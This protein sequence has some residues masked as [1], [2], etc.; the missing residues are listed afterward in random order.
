MGGEIQVTN[1]NPEFDIIASQSGVSD[2]LII[3]RTFMECNNDTSK[4]IL[5]LLNLL[6]EDAPPKEPSDIDV[7]RAILNEKDKIYHD[8]MSR[9]KE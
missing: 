1:N 2:M 4:T 6:P 5:K 9:K 7:F 3:E 8:V